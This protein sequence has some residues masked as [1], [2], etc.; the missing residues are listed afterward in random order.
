MRKAEEVALLMAQKGPVALRLAKKLI[1]EN[2]D[3]GKALEGE[4]ASFSE[5]FTTEDHIE[6]I[7]AFLEKRTPK[8]KG[9]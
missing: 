1:N 2:Q 5:C 3:I 4:I 7:N 9:R 8:F 6:G